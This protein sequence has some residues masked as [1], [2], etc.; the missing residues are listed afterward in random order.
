MRTFDLHFDKL[1]LCKFCCC[2]L[3]PSI[4]SRKYI[5]MCVWRL[6]QLSFLFFLDWYFFAINSQFGLQT[7]VFYIQQNIS[8]LSCD[9]NFFSLPFSLFARVFVP[10]SVRKRTFARFRFLSLN[11]ILYRKSILLRRPGRKPYRNF[12]CTRQAFTRRTN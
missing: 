3:S 7:V 10:I 2:Q 4:P 1:D 11:E 5:S 9:S 12:K 6:L 8:A